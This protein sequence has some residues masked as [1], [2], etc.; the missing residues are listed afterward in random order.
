MV[1]A[2]G[3]WPPSVSFPTIA[4]TCLLSSFLTSPTCLS[5]RLDYAALR[6]PLPVPTFCS[7]FI[8]NVTYLSKGSLFRDTTPDLPVI[9]LMPHCTVFTSLSKICKHV[10]I[11]VFCFKICPPPR[12]CTLCTAQCLEERRHL[13][14][15]CR[16]N[17]GVDGGA[18]IPSR[19]EYKFMRSLRCS[20]SSFCTVEC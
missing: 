9:F 2:C 19:S 20:L 4:H 15:T 12:Q 11:C 8:L 1:H 17:G 3:M 7:S 13:L 10:L 18:V 14:N 5:L 6:L 16:K